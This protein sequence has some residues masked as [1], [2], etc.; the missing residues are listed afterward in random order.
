MKAEI[1]WQPTT[2]EG[3]KLFVSDG[4]D[5]DLFIMQM[6]RAFVRE[7]PIHLTSK[8]LERLEGMSAANTIV[9][10]PY[11]TLVQHL[12]RYK[13]GITVWEEWVPTS[14][15]PQPETL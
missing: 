6:Q 4:G 9:G 14:N 1:L 13:N 5:H 12:K 10:N 8:D 7:W 15:P 3:E 11:M 2:R